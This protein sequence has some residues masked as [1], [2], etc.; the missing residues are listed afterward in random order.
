MSQR[1]L[2]PLLVRTDSEARTAGDQ[3]GLNPVEGVKGAKKHR[4]TVLVLYVCG[5]VLKLSRPFL[6]IFLIIFFQ[7]ASP[8]LPSLR[9]TPSPTDTDR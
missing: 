4:H 8:P 3:A 2:R 5:C 7:V 9:R 1:K 6:I